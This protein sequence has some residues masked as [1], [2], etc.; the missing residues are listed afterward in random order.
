MSLL[1]TASLLIGEIVV[2]GKGAKSEPFSM[3]GKS[4]FAMF[5][6]LEVAF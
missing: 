2:S 6:E 5:P 4:A 1:P 3:D